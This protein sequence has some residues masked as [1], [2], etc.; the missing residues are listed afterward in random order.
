MYK[1]FSNNKG[2]KCPKRGKKQNK[3]TIISTLLKIH[4]RQREKEIW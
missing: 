4:I 3:I 2:R 1:I